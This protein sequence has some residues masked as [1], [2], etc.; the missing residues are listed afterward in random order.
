MQQHVQSEVPTIDKTASSRVLS[1]DA[2]RGV[3]LLGILLVCAGGIGA[4]APAA[5]APEVP[6][7][8]GVSGAP[9]ALAFFL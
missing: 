8:L 2:L 5:S 1:I 7:G 6:L 4:P 3:A 9:S